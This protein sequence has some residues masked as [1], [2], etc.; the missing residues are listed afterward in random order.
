MSTGI[1]LSI[2]VRFQIAWAFSVLLLLPVV[3]LVLA[4]AY[5]NTREMRGTLQKLDPKL[6]VVSADVHMAMVKI[7]SRIL[8]MIVAAIHFFG[9][10]VLGFTTIMFGTL[11][12]DGFALF[13]ATM[14]TVLLFVVRVVDEPSPSH[15]AW[16]M[17]NPILMLAS[18]ADVWLTRF[19]KA[20]L[21]RI[22][23]H[24]AFF[25]KKS[26]AS[27]PKEEAP[28]LEDIS[29]RNG[30]RAA[31]LLRMR[32]SARHFMLVAGFV[33]TVGAIAFG[34]PLSDLG[35][36]LSGF[37]ERGMDILRITTAVYGALS[38]LVGTM[39][40]LRKPTFK[41]TR[42][43]VDDQFKRVTIRALRGYKHV[44]PD[45]DLLCNLWTD[46]VDWLAGRMDL[47]I[48]CD[49]ELAFFEDQKIYDQTNSRFCSC[50]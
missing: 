47:M 12:D 43:D 9:T 13:A 31:N 45:M 5:I 4:G 25:R 26:E 39:R 17:S 20:A 22:L 37:D 44:T 6:G 41:F 34:I 11:R 35:G 1:Y 24:A 18:S 3:G 30:I 46:G 42:R 48:Q 8:K 27:L 23:P 38:S 49:E 32:I 29:I 33:Q 2:D 50:C 10:T 21:D 19:D 16:I 14:T 36:E 40:L 15:V 7:L 28:D